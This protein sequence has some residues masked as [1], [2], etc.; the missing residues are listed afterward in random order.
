M[1]RIF[2]LDLQ[3]LQDVLLTAVAIFILFFVLSYLLFNPVRDMLEKRKKKISDELSE[4][5]KSLREAEAMKSEYDAK[6]LSAKEEAN[7]IL[8]DARK[9]ALRSRNEILE[10]ARNDVNRLKERAAQE[11][12]Q[13]KVHA[14]DDLKNEMVDIAALLAEKAVIQKMTPEIQEDLVDETL[15]EI[16]EHTWQ[17]Q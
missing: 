9:K 14:R 16:G 15:Q 2:G 8:D 10:D 1:E 7:A 6:M 17:D 11:I 12:E 4:A 5:E 13:E 3:L